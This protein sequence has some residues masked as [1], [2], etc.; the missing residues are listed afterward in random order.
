MKPYIHRHLRTGLTIVS[1]GYVKTHFLV[2]ILCIKQ[3]DRLIEHFQSG[4]RPFSRRNNL[5]KIPS[6]IVTNQDTDSFSFTGNTDRQLLFSIFSS[7]SVLNRILYRNLNN[8]G[9]NHDTFCIQSLLYYHRRC[10]AFADTT[11]FEADIRLHEIQ[12]VLQRY[13]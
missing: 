1:V 3:L 13:A 9:R 4:S 5:R 6:S 10:K 8:H 12:F 11:A 2:F 7:Q